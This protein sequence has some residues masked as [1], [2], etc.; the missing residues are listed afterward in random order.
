MAGGERRMT[1]MPERD[2]RPRRDRNHRDTPRR[3]V[4]GHAVRAALAGPVLAGPVL[5]GIM[6]LAG[7]AATPAAAQSPICRQLQ[8][9]YA[10]IQ[11]RLVA[12]DPVGD[13]VARQQ[14]ALTRAQSDH[15]RMCGIGL[16]QRPAAICPDLARRIVEMQTYLQRMQARGSGGR[17][18][19][20][21]LLQE[22]AR[23]AAALGANGCGE[24]RTARRPSGVTPPA[25]IGDGQTFQVQGPD[26]PIV[27]RQQSNGLMVRVTPTAPRPQ[28]PQRTPGFLESLF[29]APQPQPSRPAEPY[30]GDAPVEE[31]YG[32]TSGAYRTLC[33]RT[34]D[35][36]YF[37]ISH[38]ASPAQFSTDA[39]VCRARCPATET[40]LFV[41]PTDAESE[42]AVAADDPGARYQ[43]MPYALRYRT[44]VV[45]GCTCGRADPSLLPQN[46]D[47]P[48]GRRAA[49]ADAAERGQLPTPTQKPRRGDDPDSVW[50]LAAGFAPTFGALPQAGGSDAVAD[51]LKPN[52]RKVRVVGPKFFVAQ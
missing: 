46:V 12:S 5:A 11:A 48:S 16:F 52:D 43:S 41:H 38:S 1:G 32:E 20:P 50:N 47:T 26:G 18:T 13:A 49:L 23:L 19:D 25:G 24:E 51:A 28:A 2:A 42:T 3:A 36:Y 35:G 40:R 45:Q 44:Q 8:T 6:V 34:C 10:R 21:A 15:D 33:V 4:A 29:G 14:A 9:D 7:L 39:D 37:P 22:K 30:Y 17:G 27:Y 31:D